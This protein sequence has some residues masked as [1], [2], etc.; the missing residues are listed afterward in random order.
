LS[1]PTSAAGPPAVRKQ[2]LIINLVEDDLAALVKE[3][4]VHGTGVQVDA[5]VELVRL[6]VETPDMISFGMG[7][8]A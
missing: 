1:R 2:A 6:V 4:Q 5:T 3:A 8:G 7:P